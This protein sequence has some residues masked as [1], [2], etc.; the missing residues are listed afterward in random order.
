MPLGI[1]H[2]LSGTQV[3]GDNINDNLKVPEGRPKFSIVFHP[4]IPK[5]ILGISDFIAF[6]PVPSPVIDWFSLTRLTNLTI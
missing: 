1:F 4:I 3:P 6:T 5:G 2:L